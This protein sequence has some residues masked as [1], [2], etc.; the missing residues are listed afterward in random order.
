M[1]EDGVT[2]VLIGS[3]R[4]AGKKQRVD[5]LRE[6][7]RELDVEDCVKFVLNQPYSVVKDYLQRVSVG[8]HTMWYEHFG[9]G[10]VEMMAVG[11][12]TVAH[13]SGGL[14]SDII[15]QP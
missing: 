2:L 14:K 12:V 15:L 8:I 4:G 7:A 6:L 10:V 1:R 13:N 9:I 5:K 11:L 3:C